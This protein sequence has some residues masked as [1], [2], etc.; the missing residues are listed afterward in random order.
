MPTENRDDTVSGTM[1][2]SHISDTN[3][4]ENSETDVIN[5]VR[6]R[7]I[8]SRTWSQTPGFFSGTRNGNIGKRDLPMHPYH[9]STDLRMFSDGRVVD[10]QQLNFPG[11]SPDKYTTDV[12]SGV[13]QTGTS[14]APT[15][16]FG[17]LVKMPEIDLEELDARAS[18]RFLNGVKDSK[19][20]LVVAYA[21]RGQTIRLVQSLAN[22][23][24]TSV[25]AL[26]RGDFFGA[27]SALDIGLTRKSGLRL[28][29]VYNSDRSRA[30]AQFWL[31]L[32]YGLKPLLSD[33]Y[34]SVELVQQKLSPEI[35]NKLSR[36]ATKT[37]RYF[38]ESPETSAARFHI[39]VVR[40]TTIKYV[41]YFSTHQ[42]VHTLKQ[43]GITNPAL[44]AWEKAPWSFVFDWLLPIGDW[45]SSLDATN[46]LSFEKG[47]RVVFEKIT[48][49]NRGLGSY[50]AD[51]TGD[52]RHKSVNT[53]AY[54]KR[55]IVNFD[56]SV[57][58]EWPNSKFPSFKNPISWQH[59]ANAI[60]LLKTN[61][62]VR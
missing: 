62:K 8:V 23:L 43:V 24:T 37:E 35:R 53:T 59:A 44:V 18:T 1:H 41:V 12:F 21:E 51:A 49:T 52:G 15:L 33:I 29:K 58:T 17:S 27:A 14:Y 22:R 9:S 54:A 26:K 56:R 28:Q 55:R 31:E 2:L 10:K 16:E 39:E 25:K 61:L 46:G 11:T 30:F 48:I 13:I 4:S 40:A 5:Q 45:L 32:Q 60:A 19:A 57:L 7:I 50:I 47:C 38:Y 34:G 36:G 6:S 3:P 20:N 42:S